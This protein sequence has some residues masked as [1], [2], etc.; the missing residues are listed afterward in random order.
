M[1]LA[2][3]LEAPA[4]CLSS[5]HVPP[6]HLHSPVADP[7]E[8]GHTAVLAPAHTQALSALRPGLPLTPAGL[9]PGARRRPTSHVSEYLNAINPANELF[10]KMGSVL[11]P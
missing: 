11:L 7:S 1:L 4:F 8:G 3:L 6:H 10:S 2:T 5:K 9:S